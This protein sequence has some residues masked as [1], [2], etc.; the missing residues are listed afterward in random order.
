MDQMVQYSV[1][2][3]VTHVVIAVLSTISALGV[4]FLANRRIR[5]DRRD[6]G[7]RCAECKRIELELTERSRRL[8]NVQKHSPR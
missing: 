8:R 4:A 7:M 2:W 1:L 6:N 5:A 3:A